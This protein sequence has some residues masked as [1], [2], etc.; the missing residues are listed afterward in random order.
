MDLFRS[1]KPS[2]VGRA[3]LRR[4]LRP[5]K[6]CRRRAIRCHHRQQGEPVICRST[7]HGSA[8]EA[9]VDESSSRGWTCAV[10]V[11]GGTRKVS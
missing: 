1:G 2:C 8:K 3:R 6:G 5:G 7:R 4:A 10:P 11:K 9:A